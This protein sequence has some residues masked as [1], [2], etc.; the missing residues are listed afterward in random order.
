[1]EPANR[2]RVEFTSLPAN[3]AFARVAAAA[4]ASQLEFTLNDLEEIKVAVSEAVTNAIV[5][6]YESSPDKTVSLSVEVSRNTLVITVEDKGR[7]IEDVEKALQPSYSTD[8]ERMGLGFAFMQQFSDSL[9]VDSGPGAG[10]R[11]TMTR[12]CTRKVSPPVRR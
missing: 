12:A 11:V 1:M 2:M 9:K 7:G 6:G 8:P 4:F 3:V 5:H 10:T